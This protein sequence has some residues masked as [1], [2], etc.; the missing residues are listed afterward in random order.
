MEQCLLGA[1]SRTS[2]TFY[3]DTSLVAAK[4]RKAF[5]CFLSKIV[6]RKLQIVFSIFALW[7][8]RSR[9][10]PDVIRSYVLHLNQVSF[11]SLV[12]K[13]ISEQC[14]CF[15]FGSAKKH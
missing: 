12:L 4:E 15:D 1:R 7:F 2:E 13:N 10:S 11:I 6:A 14:S 8:M 3:T 5:V 9:V